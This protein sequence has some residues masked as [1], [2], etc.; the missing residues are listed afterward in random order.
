MGP[1][2]RDPVRSEAGTAGSLADGG[3]LERNG[4]R[5]SAYDGGVACGNISGGVAFFISRDHYELVSPE[6][7]NAVA[8]PS[9]A[10][11]TP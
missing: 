2:P 9:K 1:V 7:K 8:S 6:G 5:C 4:L 3:N 10:P 11:K